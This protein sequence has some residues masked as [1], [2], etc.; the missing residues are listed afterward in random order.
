MPRLYGRDG[1]IGHRVLTRHENLCAKLVADKRILDV[2]M[3]DR[4]RS[5][6]FGN[7]RLPLHR[8]SPKFHEERQHEDHHSKRLTAKSFS[9]SRAQIDERSR[10]IIGDPCARVL[11]SLFLFD[12]TDR[13]SGRQEGI[14][15][16]QVLW[17]RHR[18]SHETSPRIIQSVI[19]HILLKL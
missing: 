3:V 6:G 17:N 5:E 1:T 7:I 10:A 18:V 16:L 11:N 13:M 15:T 2:L 12:F 4:A 14:H 8:P 19:V 9:H